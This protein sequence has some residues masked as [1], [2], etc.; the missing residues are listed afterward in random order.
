M[1]YPKNI[2]IMY[3]KIIKIIIMNNNNV[4]IIMKKASGISEVITEKA[5]VI[6]VP[7]IVFVSPRFR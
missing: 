1:Y 2:I 6:S 4:I 5:Q 3:N 7:K